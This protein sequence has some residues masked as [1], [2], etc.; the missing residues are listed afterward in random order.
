M[1]DWAARGQDVSL[2]VAQYPNYEET[3]FLSSCGPTDGTSGRGTRR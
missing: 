3:G 2:W 1:Y